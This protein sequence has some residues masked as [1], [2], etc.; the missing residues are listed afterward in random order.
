[1]SLSPNNPT[2]AFAALASGFCAW[3]EAPSPEID[4][5][6]SAA[7]WLARLYASALAL[8]AVE[9]ESD[10][11]LPDIPEDELD[12][13]RRQLASFNGWY[14]REFF[15]PDPTLED[16]ACM[17]DVGDDLLDTY[18]DIKAANILF[19]QGAVNEALWHWSFSHRIHWGRHAVGALLAL[20]C[21]VISKRE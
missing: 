9:T 19:E 3:C 10:D 6:A 2:E 4:K 20:H 14:Y 16:D 1:M 15:D 18:K 11:G 17:G 21:G 12:R 13:A 8:P 5:E 7:S